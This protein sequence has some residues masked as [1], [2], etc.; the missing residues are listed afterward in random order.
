MYKVGIKKLKQ[1]AQSSIM[2]TPFGILP[3]PNRFNM[4]LITDYK[5]ENTTVDVNDVIIRLDRD[6]NQFIIGTNAELGL[7]KK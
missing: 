7:K 6:N 5:K 2:Q 3:D 4:L 1:F